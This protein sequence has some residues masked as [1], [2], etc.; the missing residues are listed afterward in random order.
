MILWDYIY[1]IPGYIYAI[2]GYIYAIPSYIR[3]L[4]LYFVV[5]NKMNKAFSVFFTHPGLKDL[6]KIP[7]NNKHERSGDLEYIEGA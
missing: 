3:M 7:D 6:L 4:R 5:Y 2:P 1:A